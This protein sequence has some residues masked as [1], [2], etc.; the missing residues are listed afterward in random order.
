MK[1]KKEALLF[2]LSSVVAVVHAVTVQTPQVNVEVKKGYNATLQCI[3]SVSAARQAGDNV[4]WR[5]VPVSEDFAYKLLS[6]DLEYKGNYGDRLTFSGDVNKGN[7]S[8]TLNQVTMD[9]NGTFECTVQL[10][11][12]PPSSRVLMNLLVL[13]PPSKPTCT[14]IGKAE[15][16]RNINLTCHSDEG[17]P[18]P[19][20]TWQSYDAQ[21][22]PRQLVGT[23]LAGGVLILKNISAESTGY[24][25]CLSHNTAGDEK[26]NISL[27]VVPQSMNVALYAGIIGGAVAAIVIIAVLVYCCC[28]RNSKD[29]EYE[30][31]ENDDF[32][33][34]REPIRIRGP[35][36]E[37]IQEEDEEG[38]RPQR[39]LAGS[40]EAV[41]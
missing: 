6:S 35:S 24:Y 15:Y 34:H 28:C 14:I 16:G 18:E 33:P 8:I 3:F 12:D 31:S 25:T 38:H 29:K 30:P 1:A 39:P 36:E 23:P 26:C 27:A 17:S 10:F 22:Q 41:A 2:M 40:S 4:S 21:N 7:G 20:Y 19:T 32:Q 9:D 11:K 13:V 37:E 5:K